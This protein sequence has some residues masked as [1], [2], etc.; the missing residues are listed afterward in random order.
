MCD[1]GCAK[2]STFCVRCGVDMWEYSDEAKADRWCIECAPECYT[3]GIHIAALR[4][5]E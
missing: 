1:A 4:A 5:V 3:G 2:M